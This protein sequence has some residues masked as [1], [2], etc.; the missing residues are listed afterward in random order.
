MIPALESL[1]G[2][3]CGAGAACTPTRLGCPPLARSR[4]APPRTSAPS[5]AAS[6]GRK[7]T[8]G[9]SENKID[10][11]TTHARCTRSR[12]SAFASCTARSA[13]ALAAITSASARASCSSNKP[14]LVSGTS[15]VRSMLGSEQHKHCCCPPFPYRSLAPRAALWEA[16][17]SSSFCCSCLRS[18]SASELL[19]AAAASARVTSALARVTWT[20]RRRARVG[21]S[22]LPKIKSA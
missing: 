17:I 1:S 2:A 14:T 22:T 8:K 11:Y 7:Q 3:A 21:V 4:L 16:R 20:T 6:V 18:S 9:A 5:I 19:L 12:A 13:Y 10:C 15:C